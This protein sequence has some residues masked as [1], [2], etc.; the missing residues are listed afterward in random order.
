MPIL[1]HDFESR[2]TLDLSDVGTWR[3]AADSTTDVWCCS[4]AVDD[5][6]VELWVP[7]NSVPAAFIEAANN[8]DWLV[9]AFND[10]FE[11]LI[12][13]HI[14][15][16]RYGW[17]TIPIE[18]H[19]CL[20]AAAASLALPRKLEKV[21]ETLALKNQKDMQGHKVMLQMSKPRR[22]RKNED[23]SKLYWFDDDHRREILYKYCKQDTAV[24]RELHERIG[25]LTAEEQALW[26]LDAAVNDRG[27]HIDRRLLDA[28]IRI[29]GNV[30]ST[31][32]AELNKLTEGA[33]ESVYQI[34]R[35]LDWLAAHD[36]KIPNLSKSTLEKA[37]AR[38]E[39]PPATRRVLELRL[40]GAHA[41][42]AKL[43]TMRDWLTT[44]NRARGC[45]KFHGAATGRWT[46]HGIQ[47]QN[48]K[49]PVVDDLDAAIEA[50]YAGDLGKYPR[51]MSVVGD[52][53][54]ALI[55]AQPGHKFIAADFSGVESRITAWLSGQESKLAQWAKFDQTQDP[56]DEP[57]FLIGRDI[58][59]IAKESA[60][61]IGKTGDLA[62]GYMGGIGA[63]RKLAPGDNSTDEQI[64][65]RQY[66][67]RDAHPMTRDFWTVLNRKTVQAVSTPGAEIRFQRFCWQRL[68][69]KSDG[70]FLR[71]ILPSGRAIAYPFPTLKNDNRGK[72]CVVFMDNA[73]GKW[74][75]CRGGNGAYGGTWLEN[76]VQAVAR[77][78]FA[79]A[80]QR[81]E[82]AGYKIV[83]HVH[84]E[85]VAEVPQG[86]GSSEEFLRILISA[87]DWATGLPI[88]AKV[89]NGPRF[90]KSTKSASEPPP[91]EQPAEPE[92]QPQPE[93]PP[94]T[95]GGDSNYGQAYDFSK[96]T[97]A[98]GSG[99]GKV[100]KRYVYE[101]PAGRPYLR[102]NRTSTHRFFQE[103]WKDG[104]WI[105]GKPLGGPIP[106]RLPQ[107]IAA[108]PIE[109]VI[110]AEGEK[111]ADTAADLG[112]VATCNPAGA[113]KFTADLARWLVGKEHVIICED[114][115]AAGRAHVAKTAA[116]LHGIVPNIRVA[117]FT[118]LDEKGDL[119]D[120]AAQ[121][122]T[123]N[124]LLARAQPAP[125]PT[126]E[127]VRAS[128][129]KPTRVKW[130]WPGRFARGKLGIVAGLPDEG[131]GLLFYHIIACITRGRAW[132]CS[133]GVAPLGNVI[134]LT[135]EDDLEDT[136]I[137]RLIAAGADLDRI[138]ILRMVP[139]GS[140]KRMFSLVTDLEML[141]RKIT[142]VG[143][144]QAVFIDPIT[145][146]LG[147]K[148][149]DSFRTTDVRAV[150]A[151]VVDLAIELKVSILV[152]M[153][154]NK[155]IDVT[156][157]LLRISDSLAF[158]AT[159]RHCYAVVYDAENKRSLL[160]KGKNNLAP[161]DQKALAF[162]VDVGDGGIDEETGATI[163]APYITFAP[164]PVDVTAYEAMQAAADCKSL[165][166]RDS[167][168]NFLKDMLAAGRVPKE[169]IEE[170]AEAN[171]IS[172]RTLRRAKD[173]LKVIAEKDR[174]SPQ[175]KWF[176][177]LPDTQD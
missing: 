150:L 122:Y 159:S 10:Q 55:S 104:Q 157:V 112:F 148:Q 102:V 126:V 94:H 78:L 6:P 90:C 62:F 116:V 11:R 137:P 38:P 108:K 85:I 37:L 33:V 41:A 49:R 57:Y 58:F 52:I 120:W 87:P 82:S 29:T 101:D 45:F 54:R 67:W 139:N 166:A 69:F 127:S 53:T 100:I 80:M 91:W 172:L 93:P 113:G 40:D 65:G 12:E 16:P 96:Y 117:R 46:S 14:M 99:R 1:H 111:D 144:V 130:I 63:Y 47:V 66:A 7:G 177:R 89:R 76:A 68:S 61:A 73:A 105:K 97:R 77:D 141:R 72:P 147:V 24:E 107:L 142:E 138:E 70:T 176:W 25:L 149:I 161:K 79:A 174:T 103:H 15:G 18:R 13:Q 2:S 19:R 124:D 145:A 163:R 74:T 50:V 162:T 121:G 165:A 158:G 160:V 95:N 44:D 30:R 115:D 36:C 28:A 128:D 155:K 153:H 106:Y 129:I 140:G 22:R 152:I 34:A 51:P 21:A 84:D 167:A 125:E 123:R 5:G 32:S 56:A 109:V 8:P 86:F 75:E 23:P 39:L 27:I 136:V 173:E 43:A 110:I 83:L 81:L 88:A 9:C 118:D 98:S 17:P 131:K 133:E 132:P 134:L 143:N 146:Y 154:F 26:L 20:Q 114:N 92:S 169:E 3:Y 135:A 170:A 64:K 171:G 175:G 151:P 119:S 71:M 48:L 31:I 60:R 35:M 4:Y 59:G 168:K 156:N 42:V 164:D